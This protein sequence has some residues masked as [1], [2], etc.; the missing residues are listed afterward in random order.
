MAY[1]EKEEFFDEIVVLWDEDMTPAN[2]S[3]FLREYF[4]TRLRASP[5]SRFLFA[6]SGHG[7]QDGD[8]SYVLMNKATSFSDKAHAI[9]LAELRSDVAQT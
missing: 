3:Y 4:P 2:L 7:F 5:K 1:L 6:Y 8:Q 9:D